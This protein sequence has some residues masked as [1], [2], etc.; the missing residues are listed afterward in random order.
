MNA[1]DVPYSSSY[2]GPRGALQP[3]W[4][5]S[6]HSPQVLLHRTDTA[7]PQKTHPRRPTQTVV[8]KER[9][10]TPEVSVEA[11]M[12]W[13]WLPHHSNQGQPGVL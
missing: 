4:L 6:T 3:D 1:K 9:R 8:T 11:G 5:R 2:C 12:A 7:I 10:F 13:P